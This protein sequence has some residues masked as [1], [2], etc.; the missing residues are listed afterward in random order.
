MK[1][2]FWKAWRKV[3]VESSMVVVVVVVV[4]VAALLSFN[5]RF[6]R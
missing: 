6:R 2:E 3:A 4:A 5:R 1:C